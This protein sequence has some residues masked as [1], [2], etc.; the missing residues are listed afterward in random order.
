MCLCCGRRYQAAAGFLAAGGG[1]AV[2]Y[3]GAKVGKALRPLLA[4]AGRATAAARQKGG[5]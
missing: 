3:V 2:Q 4:G 1:K 5:G